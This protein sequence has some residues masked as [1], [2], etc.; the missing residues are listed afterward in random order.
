MPT[1]PCS[2]EPKLIAQTLFLGASV[3]SF[4]T[5]L[6]WGNQPSQLTVNLVEDD[7][8]YGCGKNQNPSSLSA[9]SGMYDQYLTSRPVSDPRLLTYTDNHYNTCVGDN[10]YINKPDSVMFN[11]S[12]HG[13]E[14]R[15]LP[16]KVYYALDPMM[17]LVS[18]YWTGPD[19]GFFGRKTR[20][21]E[22]GTYNSSNQDA[23][24]DYAYDI[25]DTPVYFKMGNF[26]FGG[27]VQSWNRT[28]STGGKSYSVIVN[29][30]QSILNSCYVIVDKYGGSIF[31]KSTSSQATNFYGSPK[32]YLL[33]AGAEYNLREL[34]R[35]VLPNVFNVYGFLESF[36]VDGFGVAK[37][38]D[39][40]VSVNKIVEGLIALTSTTHTSINKLDT[41]FNAAGIEAL[42]KA[43]SPFGRIISKCMQR[44]DYHTTRQGGSA[45]NLFAPITPA[46]N[47]F[48][49]INPQVFNHFVTPGAPTTRCQ[50]VLDLADL[51][52]TDDSRQTYKIPNDIRVQGPIIS[53]M[54]LIN[55]VAEQT[56][57][58]IT[59]D[60][61]PTI[62]LRQ[63]YHVIKVRAVSRLQQPRSN[64]IDNTIKLLQC[65][66][67]PVSSNTS[68]KEKNDT[69]ARAMIIGGS[70]QRL[71]QIQSYRLAY[72]QSSFVFDPKNKKFINYFS[73]KDG[74]SLYNTMPRLSL[75]QNYGHGKIRFPNFNS[76]RN[77]A[78]ADAIG[79]S[80]QLETA[81]VQIIK[82][83][84]EIQKV[85][86]K[87]WDTN[88]AVWTTTPELND[89][90][91][92]HYGNY[93]PATKTNHTDRFGT[94]GAGNARWFPIHLD[95]ICPF[96]G[97]VHDNDVAFKT[98]AGSTD[99]TTSTREIRPVFF[100]TWTGQLAVVIRVSEL[101]VMSVSLTRAFLGSEDPTTGNEIGKF[102]PKF[103]L[104]YTYQPT[105]P[106]ADTAFNSL[107]AIN[108][109]PVPPIE[110]FVLTESEI[111]AA[112]AGFDNFLVYSLAKTYKPDLIEMVRRAYFVETKNKLMSELGLNNNDATK[113]AS[114]Q[115]DWY[116]KLLGSNIAGDSLYPTVVSP[117]KNDG[118]QYIQEKALQDLK[119]I[120]RFIAEVGKFY[121]KKYMV[122][123]G[124]A[125]QCFRDESIANIAFPTN[126][127]Y[128][129][130]FS[131]DGK[132]T[133]N[134]EPTNDGAWEEYGNIIDDGIV[135]GSSEWYNLS[136]DQGKIKPLLGYNNN[137][138]FDYIR[139][140]KCEASKNTN[141][142]A[143]F[144]KDGGNPY[145]SYSAWLALTESKR[146]DCTKSFVFP[147]L[148]FT[149]L[150]PTDYVIVDQKHSG[151][152]PS[153][154]TNSSFVG[155]LR[156]S[157]GVTSPHTTLRNLSLSNNVKSYDAWNVEIVDPTGTI[158]MPMPRSKLYTSTSVEEGY[159]FL[160]PGKLL[161][162]RILIDAPGLT[163]NVSSTENAKDPNRTVLSNLAA[164]DLIVYL[165]T[166]SSLDWDWIRYMLN[167]I[168]PASYDDQNNPHYLGLYT[169][170]SNSSAN[171]VELAPKAAHPF[172][173]G[174]PIKSNKFVYGPWINYPDVE[175]FDIY[176]TGI[177]VSQTDTIPPVCTNVS[178][179]QPN[180][181]EARKAIE[182]LITSIDIEVRDDFV[183]WNYGGMNSLDIA[184][185][186]EIESR[187]NYQSVIETAQLD[188]PGLPLFD[189]GGIFSFGGINYD[190]VVNTGNLIYVDAKRITETFP[191][192]SYIP[193]AVV[194]V[195]PPPTATYIQAYT[196]LDLKANVK[197]SGGPMISNIQCSIGQQGISTSYS[198][199]TYTRKIG[200]FNKEENDRI[201]KINLAN[202]KRNKQMVG[203][204]QELKNVIRNQKKTQDDERLDK[205]QFGS[206]DLSSKLFGWSPSMVLIGQAS[207]YISEPSRTPAYVEDFSLNSTTVPFQTRIQAP[208]QWSIPT[209]STDQ[210]DNELVRNNNNYLTTN[211]S[212]TTLK[213]TGRVT[214]TVQLYERKE[215]GSQLDKDYGT[216]SAMSLDGL[217]SPIS[218]Y[219]T[220]KNA[221]FSYSVHMTQ[222]CPF[223][224]GTKVR[225]IK[226]VQYDKTGTKTV[227]NN[228]VVLI[229]C[230]KCGAPGEKLNSRI[231]NNKEIP[232]NLITL[233]PIVVPDGE[234]KNVNTQNYSGAHPEGVH[235]D[236]SSA[237]TG[238]GGQTRHFRD[239][240]R[241][242][243]EIVARGSVP[244]NQSKYALETSRNLTA[245]TTH[246]AELEPRNL[247][248]SR[249][250][251]QLFFKMSKLSPATNRVLH[252]NNQRFFGLRG[253]LVLHSWGY[254]TDGY[255][256]P[257]AADEPYAID[258]FGRPKRFK[259]KIVRKAAVKY[260]M[261]SV[262]DMFEISGQTT[263]F[264]KSLNN[265]NLPG[266]A[267]ANLNRQQINDTMVIPIFLED[268]LA[269]DGGFEPENTTTALPTTLDYTSGY[270]GSII[271][272][273]Q[274]FLNNRWTQKYRLKE[275]Y[276]NWAERPDLWRVGPID[277]TWDDDRKL[278]TAGQGCGE[279]NPPF[280]V[281]NTNDI[282][283]IDEFLNYKR[284]S[285][286]PY[287]DIYVTLEEDLVKQPDYDETYATRAF[288]DD[289]EFSKQPL[290][291]G[292]RRLVYVKDKCG[293][294]APMG[295]KL[296]C[297]YNKSTG[298]YEPLTKPVMIA[299]G[300]T[301]SAN[302]ARLTLEYIQGR[303][304]INAPVLTVNF[305]NPV[306][307]T[308]ASDK[309]AMFTFINGKWTLTAI[310]E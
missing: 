35:G 42:K 56:G 84:Y 96:F 57:H 16:G 236:I 289:M 262:G 241:H 50:F 219:P 129:Y 234:F 19:P 279:E 153:L 77:P 225:K 151:P 250:D 207:P 288:I 182:N 267:W 107:G 64:T 44:E 126:I 213:N 90:I 68:G 95:L 290:Q 301:S 55:L 163:L 74:P 106:V 259:L 131:G 222:N 246:P 300:I 261:L 54:D 306:G 155:G 112:L 208:T 177:T 227:A 29:S 94:A 285:K 244:P 66:G 1:Q 72:T 291:A 253:P 53:V 139:Q 121:G 58:D 122:H 228:G 22:D 47:E 7:F 269:V 117:D 308:V 80:N 251:A 91:D 43:F 156:S 52:Y 135:V 92:I 238:Y 78:L 272:K 255:P 31:S 127:G 110:Y 23:H 8:A 237:S 88:D 104:P 146:T 169:V 204:G 198:F 62:W 125:L 229:V 270:K 307:F 252:E 260:K 85:V 190:Y 273:T 214:A 73:L 167:Y 281:T 172:F 294:C 87:Q 210:G 11:S 196:V 98:S 17:G 75:T 34:S 239:R 40:G 179:Y 232:I 283:T 10:C 296:L 33:K 145:F 275:F 243:I 26:S 309:N 249:Y 265:Q 286:C 160:D 220:Y 165:K 188:M 76:T 209:T 193:G 166:T 287:R 18:R 292:Y 48:G 271:S 120:H 67:Y 63:L 195:G 83:E 258:V 247:D 137:Y 15:I 81:F 124:N 118:S 116:W 142:I 310:K 105:A 173:A 176:P 21:K 299:K 171:N 233:N 97:Y 226:V 211:T 109:G 212:P 69:P 263:I 148:D 89:G 4:N 32:N 303:R 216:Q 111:R 157:N 223:C 3:S 217:L 102:F 264:S 192:L 82:D 194:A 235:E 134:Y 268:D 65:S 274:K 128:G 9:G 180:V 5:S 70:Q 230:D 295:T 24:P 305:D 99:S 79:T 51:I 41:D 2:N 132:I 12:I 113:E 202:L 298:F 175:K 154:S 115:T 162:A 248:Y 138:Y 14:N 231:K 206:E 215:V 61:V 158:P 187:I 181:D 254:D 284:E 245:Y 133:Y 37:P 257:N 30:A 147:S 205:S 199:R 184:A 123:P 119:I 161:G 164:E 49:V 20:M 86:S 304:S 242:C 159:V 276:L 282:D 141:F 189:L 191:D 197:P 93:D 108:T 302:Q 168:T 266:A 174:I 178:V 149:G 136:D 186:K 277:L 203:I 221:T 218:F 100:D 240:M 201:K 150:N 101:P 280:V 183:P 38:S 114:D 103:P 170:S 143:D 200:L 140:A 39:N 278:W 60:M 45:N 6:G 256:I 36:G 46:F 224:F 28:V 71:L 152:P 25:I 13:L 144:A 27:F 59:I 293:Y 130:A 297:R 185:Y